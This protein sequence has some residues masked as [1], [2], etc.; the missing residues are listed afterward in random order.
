MISAMALYINF[1]KE[2]EPIETKFA[3]ILF[4]LICV[5]SYTCLVHITYMCA[6][7][8]HTQKSEQCFMPPNILL[9]RMPPQIQNLWSRTR[10]GQW[11]QTCAIG[12]PS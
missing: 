1:T 9:Y 4:I 12:S 2:D 10:A 6:F 8:H 3:I 11:Q 5:L 7:I